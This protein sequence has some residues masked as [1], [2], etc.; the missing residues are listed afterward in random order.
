MWDIDSREMMDTKV[1]YVWMIYS[2]D[3]AFMKGEDMARFIQNGPYTLTPSRATISRNMTAFVVGT[4]TLGILDPKV[5][6]P[7][8]SPDSPWEAL[9]QGCQLLDPISQ[10]ADM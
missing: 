7:S 9:W 4:E 8:T 1:W 2:D 5:Q 6:I 3:D 10:W